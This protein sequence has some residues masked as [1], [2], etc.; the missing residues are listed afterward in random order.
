MTRPKIV[1]FDI[2]GTVFSL[3][4][5]R[6]PL[7]ALGLPPLALEFVYAAALRDTFA[8]AATTTFAPFL[9]VLEACLDEV[10]ALHGLSAPAQQKRG[11]LGTMEALPAHDDAGAAFETLARAG[12]GI[13]ALSNGSASVTAGLLRGAGLNGFVEHVL[14]V[15]DVKLSKPRPEVYLYATQAAGVAPEA[16]MLVAAHPWDIHG[17][18]VADLMGGYVARGR[19]FPPT[20]KAPDIWGDDLLDVARRIARL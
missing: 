17:A 3:E 11:V 8:M 14:S 15:E 1:A 4:P 10:L 19:P 5:L 16:T 20:L 2:I 7:T 12:V 13:V 18:K 9:S 6:E